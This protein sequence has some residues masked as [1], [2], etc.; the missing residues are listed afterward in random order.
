MGCTESG[1]MKSSLPPWLR[2]GQGRHRQ[3][4][5]TDLCCLIIWRLWVFHTSFLRRVWLTGLPQLADW[6][7]SLQQVRTE[8]ASVACLLTNVPCGLRS[9]GIDGPEV[10]G[11]SSP[12]D[13]S[14]ATGIIEDTGSL[15][16]SRREKPAS[17]MAWLRLPKQ[18]LVILPLSSDP[19]SS[20][21]PVYTC[22]VSH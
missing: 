9:I 10:N 16:R 18:S 7:S 13:C 2:A 21:W 3:Q 8:Q 12:T 6:L 4:Q 22:Q 1:W 19:H 5:I 17:E 14:K 11:L 15:L 20:P